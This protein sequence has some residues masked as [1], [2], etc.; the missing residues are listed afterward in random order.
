VSRIRR[1]AERVVAV[2]MESPPHAP[3]QLG[4]VIE[5]L[6]VEI[7]SRHLPPGILGTSRSRLGQR[8]LIEVDLRMP[9]TRRNFTIAHEVGHLLLNRSIVIGALIDQLPGTPVKVEALCDA[10]AGSLLVPR[11]WIWSLSPTPP[12]LDELLDLASSFQ[13]SASALCIQL[14]HSG[15]EC[16]LGTAQRTAE[17]W[18]WTGS[19]GDLGGGLRAWNLNANALEDMD[20][21]G[22]RAWTYRRRGYAPRDFVLDVSRGTD[23]A[24]VWIRPTQWRTDLWRSE[25][26]GCSCHANREQLSAGA[27]ALHGGCPETGAEFKATA[28]TTRSAKPPSAPSAPAR[29]TA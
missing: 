2:G 7:R 25:K 15:R 17:G 14:S 4:S 28:P 8:P 3:G 24:R 6:D 19:H 22:P 12:T 27:R 9:P 21:S 18:Q 29:A 1:L 10:I 23:S 16:L 20:S 26:S 11:P 5:E 13:V